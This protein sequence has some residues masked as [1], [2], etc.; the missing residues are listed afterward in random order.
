MHQTICLHFALTAT[1]NGI[2]VEIV[3][4]IGQQGD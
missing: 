2:A 3:K 4:H 1:V